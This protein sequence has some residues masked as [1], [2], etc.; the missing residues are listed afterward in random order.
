MKLKKEKPGKRYVSIFKKNAL[1]F[2]F[3]GIIPML[4]MGFSIYSSYSGTIQQT[5]L[6]NLSQMSVYVGKNISDL[7]G[8]MDETTK[9]L[10]N[11]GITDYD[12]FYELVLDDEISETK[13]EAMITDVLRS[14]LYTN[15][16]ISQVFFV[17]PDGKCYSGMRP[18]EIHINQGAMRNFH[19]KYYDPKGREGV[20]IPSHMNDYYYY[21]SD[22][23]FSAGRN[24]MNT[25]SLQTAENE[26]LGTIYLDIPVRWIEE[27]VEEADFADSDSVSVIDAGEMVYVYDRDEV[28]IR[29]EAEELKDYIPLMTGDAPYIRTE[30]DYLIYSLIPGT[31]WIIVDKVAAADIES[32]FR[33]IRDRTLLLIVVSALLLGIIYL[34]YNRRT[35]LPIAGMR[36]AMIRIQNGE[37]DTRVDI[38]TN[39]ELGIIAE[40]LNQ[41]TAKLQDHIGQV[42]IAK[43]KQR[44]AELEALKT[45]IQPHYLYN[46]LD[47]IRMTAVTNDD[48]LTAE[49]L[50]SLSGQL[51]YLI[52][53]NRDL[54]PLK[55]E[56]DSI[57]N[58]FKLIRIRFDNRFD[59][60]VDIADELMGFQVPQLIIQPIVENA[61][62]HGLRPKPGAGRVAIYAK[63][64]QDFL[65]VVVMDNGVGM[66]ETQL[67]SVRALLTGGQPGK[68]NDANWESI[69]LKNV[70]DRIRLLFGPDYGFEIDGYEGIGTIVKYRLPVVKEGVSAGDGRDYV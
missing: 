16:K 40:G 13:R 17:M 27:A 58:Y 68:R 2:I 62:K 54:V 64:Q 43:I 8:E 35:S 69:G 42:Y 56:I 37:L 5:L 45:Q 48:P 7:C 41:M 34:F 32:Q 67:R 47:V 36:E 53:T 30:Q 57:R 50:D 52:G 55:A 63:R 4:L 25:K 39:D 28:N 51:K 24:I 19:E 14:V 60:E 21:Q 18:P 9:Y 11:Y 15:Q 31:D 29:Y 20:L 26:V 44:D 1:A 10:Y 46:T 33:Q 65:E 22:M 12:Y 3:I 38:H 66:S 49:M 6:S 70:Y 59:L 23:F 61:V